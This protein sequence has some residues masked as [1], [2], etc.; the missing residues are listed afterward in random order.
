[1][2]LSKLSLGHPGSKT[3]CQGYSSININI[4]H[5]SFL[6]KFSYLKPPPCRLFAAAMLRYVLQ[7]HSLNTVHTERGKQRA[8]AEPPAHFPLAELGGERKETIESYIP[9]SIVGP[10]LSRE[11]RLFHG[12][13]LWKGQHQLPWMNKRDS[14]SQTP[15]ML[16]FNA[17]TMSHLLPHQASMLYVRLR[18]DY[19]TIQYL[20]LD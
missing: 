9:T 6:Q 2:F 3:Q 4:Y 17:P 7:N 10:F 12:G 20:T 8:A 18:M 14:T 13:M 5:C 15:F 16:E 1:M 19:L 11:K